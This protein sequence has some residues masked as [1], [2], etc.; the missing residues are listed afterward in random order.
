MFLF[1]SKIFALKNVLSI[2]A[3]TSLAKGTDYKTPCVLPCFM[4]H[5]QDRE[6]PAECAATED[7]TWGHHVKT[8][9]YSVVTLSNAASTH[10]SSEPWMT[11][12]DPDQALLADTGIPR[13]KCPYQR[14]PSF[15]GNQGQVLWAEDSISSRTQVCALLFLLHAAETESWHSP[16]MLQGIPT[17]FIPTLTLIMRCR[18]A[19][20]VLRGT[21]HA[22]ILQRLQEQS[23]EQILT[24]GLLSD[25]RS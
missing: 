10:C 9:H 25:F 24:H 21:C 15:G 1:G 7:I 3:R 16:L 5:S 23:W 11:R 14:M 13:Q 19:G 6:S 4:C 22:L 12:F 18:G 2:T 20:P 17:E 8:C